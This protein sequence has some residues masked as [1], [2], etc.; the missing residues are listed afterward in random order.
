MH[1]AIRA[2]QLG[3]GRPFHGPTHVRMLSIGDERCDPYAE[4][5]KVVNVH[6]LLVQY[7]AER[8]VPCPVCKYNLRGLTVEKCPECGQLLGLSI[9]AADYRYGP[10]SAAVIGAAGGAWFFWALVIWGLVDG[11]V[12]LTD[13]SWDSIER[14]LVLG[15][16]MTTLVLACVLI[17]SRRI[18]RAS[19]AGAWSIVAAVWMLSI[20]ATVAFMDAT[21]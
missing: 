19:P 20:V 4:D 12:T 2:A 14:R 18:R 3:L 8:D 10:W 13:G 9:R 11:F 15:W 1:S 6:A 5:M 21:R 7:L 16:V 17:Y